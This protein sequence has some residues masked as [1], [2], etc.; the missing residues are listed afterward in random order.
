M[1]IIDVFNPIIDA[2]ARLIGMIYDNVIYEKDENLF[3]L[4]HV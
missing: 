1:V 3:L 4:C 2:A